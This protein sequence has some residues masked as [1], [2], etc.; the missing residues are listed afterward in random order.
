MSTTALIVAAGT[1][2]RMGEGLPKPYLPLGAKTV[3]R[4]SIDSFLAHPD[5]DHIQVVINKSHI[6]LYKQSVAGLD[7]PSP[8]IGGKSRGESVLNGLS[9]LTT[10]YVLVHDAAR[11]FVPVETIDALS[12]ILTKG[13]SGVIPVLPVIDTIK[14][15]EDD[16]V[17]ETLDRSHLTRVQTPQG[18]NVKILKEAYEKFGVYETDDAGLLEKM[19]QHVLTINGNEDLFKITTYSDYKRALNMTQNRPCIGQGYDVH[20][21]VEGKEIILGGVR[22]PFDK[23][24]EGHSDA[25]VVLHALTDALLGAAALADIGYHFPPSDE[26]WKDADSKDMLEH[27]VGLVHDKGVVVNNA[28]ITIICEAPKISPYRQEIQAIIANILKIEVDFVNIKATTTEKLG[29]VGREEGIA[30]Q[31]VVSVFR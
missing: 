19:G 8:V 4:H 24:L 27:V 10:E 18:F 30:S 7:L 22:I 21:L 12:E 14:Y 3:L 28:D 23:S 13:G 5:I 1:S 2:S 15:I 6:E 20:K 16:C 25:D 29:F 31:A 11:P 17:K 26:K 9:S